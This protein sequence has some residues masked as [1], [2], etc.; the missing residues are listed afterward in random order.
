MWHF[1]LFQLPA[2]SESV[3]PMSK[4]LVAI[5]IVMTK[6]KTNL[7]SYRESEFDTQSTGVWNG[8]DIYDIVSCTRLKWLTAFNQVD[9]FSLL[10]LR[11][12][13][14]SPEKRY[15]FRVLI[16]WL[17]RQ[18]YRW[19]QESSFRFRSPSVSISRSHLFMQ[20]LFFVLALLLLYLI[21]RDL[22][23]SVCVCFFL[24]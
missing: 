5:A 17:F 24:F 13:F 11:F 9:R 19:K 10:L 8:M 3:L 21:W 22:E 20:N 12:G 2:C 16:A 14:K 6:F 15:H 7:I 18:N 23:Q 4:T 1:K